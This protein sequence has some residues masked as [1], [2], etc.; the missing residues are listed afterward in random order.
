MLYGKLVEKSIREV[1]QEKI[2]Q[3]LYR[4]SFKDEILNVLFLTN[5]YKKEGKSG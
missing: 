5:I 1:I 3:G 2:E 4:E